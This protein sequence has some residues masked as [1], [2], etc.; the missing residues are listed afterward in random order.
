[1]VTSDFRPEVEIQPF[2]ARAMHLHSLFIVDLAIRPIPRSTERIFSSF[3]IFLFL[4][5][6][7]L[8]STFSS[9]QNIKIKG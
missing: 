5:F 7:H 6:I 8:F 3:F 9:L 4:S 2:R 1:M